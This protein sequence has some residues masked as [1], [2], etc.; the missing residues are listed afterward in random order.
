MKPFMD[1]EFL[2][3]TET[4][5]HL[6]HNHA[7]RMPIVD[8]HCHISPQEIAE[9]KQF[10]SITEAWLAGD[11][12]KWRQIRSNGT[13]EELI[14]GNADDFTKF[15]EYAKVL[16][17]LMGNPL[18]HW[19]HLELKRYFG[20]NTPL[21]EKTA[22]EIF[23]TANKKIQSPDMQ[24]LNLIKKSNV[25][26]ICTTDDPADDLKWHKKIKEDG[27]CSSQVLPALRPD[28]ALNPNNGGFAAYIETLS[29]AAGMSI[30]TMKD[31]KNALV[32]RIAFFHE[33]GGRASDH[34]LV[35]TFWREESDMAIEAIF[36][37]AM[38]G[39]TL[40]ATEDEAYK[41]SLFITLA[42]EYTKLNWGMEL[43]FAAIRN[44]NTKMF[45]KMGADTGFDAVG[46]G[47]NAEGLA[48]F[49][50]GLA[51]KGTLPK[52][53]I[54]SL[55]PTDNA[56]IGSV[57]G[58]FQDSGIHGKIQQGAAWWFNDTKRGMLEQLESIA[59]LSVLGNILGMLTDSRSFLSYTRHEYFRRILCNYIGNMVENGEYPADMSYL[60]KIIEDICYNNVVNY[61]NF[62][63]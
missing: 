53:I 26:V 8:Y 59:D 42:A 25:K 55:N 56:V 49:L 44:L 10:K 1:E 39:E 13:Q 22:K 47:I 58:C 20:I 6:Y 50:N 45:D 46:S 63:V 60:G 54:F 30:S 32:K 2:L 14:T 31:L 12:Y 3:E 23:E 24:V 17:R 35:H 37:K 34:A 11:H 57:I 5:K 52:T 62:E 61:F 27:L 15:N 9:N 29:K 43:H 28:K 19:S 36:Q 33:M 21:N 18:Y 38:R 48:A 16:P 7:E 40:S 41:T 4:A 51:K